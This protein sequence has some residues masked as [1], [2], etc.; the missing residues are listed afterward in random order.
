MP[1]GMMFTMGLWSMMFPASMKL[2]WIIFGVATKDDGATPKLHCRS[3][4]VT[5]WLGISILASLSI[6]NNSVH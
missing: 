6:Q 5:T 1:K 3:A 4:P 2:D